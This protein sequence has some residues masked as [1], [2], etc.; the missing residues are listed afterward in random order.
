[1][2]IPFLWRLRPIAGR[3]NQFLFP[4]RA[5]RDT[6]TRFWRSE[7]SRYVEWYHGRTLPLYGFAC[8]TESE[9]VSSHRG[10]LED[11]LDTWLQV[12]QI[13]KYLGILNLRSDAFEG[14]TVLDIGCGPFPNLAGFHGCRRIGVDPLVFAYERAGFPL[15]QW[16]ANQLYC[17][18]PAESIPLPAASVDA[19]V[20]V[21]ALDHVDDFARTASEVRR[22]LRKD[23]RFRVQ[24]HYH[25]RTVTEPIELN[26]EIFLQHFGWIPGLRKI[27]ETAYTNLGGTL[28]GPG[29]R[30]V[31]WGNDEAEAATQTPGF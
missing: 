31:L 28:A 6:E 22:V 3:C 18:A 14:K 4:I 11:A 19:V 20:S 10:E 26:D 7:L 2:E 9:R 1:M 27:A 24:V 12:V 5:K 21:N 8:P 15:A 16:S 30:Y 17:A 13:P 29:E 23:G 25:R